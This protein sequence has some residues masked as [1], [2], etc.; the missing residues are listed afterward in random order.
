MVTAGRFARVPTEFL[1][2]LQVSNM[3]ETVVQF[4]RG[5]DIR[6]HYRRTIHINVTDNLPVTCSHSQI[7]VHM[8]IRLTK[9]S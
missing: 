5:H 9:M 1:L 2:E 8:A 6:A 4:M 7:I 3:P